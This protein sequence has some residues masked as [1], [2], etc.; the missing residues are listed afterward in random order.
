M[1]EILENTAFVK[2]SYF[3]NVLLGFDTRNLLCGGHLLLKSDLFG[4]IGGNLVFRRRK[5]TMEWEKIDVDGWTI[6]D[7][8]EL[9]KKMNCLSIKDIKENW[10]GVWR[11]KY[12]LL[13]L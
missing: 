1:L 3:V 11:I 2:S 6:N 13:T 12:Y 8:M 7:I 4:T 10:F 9:Y 5:R